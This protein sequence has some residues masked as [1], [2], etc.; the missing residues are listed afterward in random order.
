MASELLK[1]VVEFSALDDSN[2]IMGLKQINF[3]NGEVYIHENIYDHIAF[4]AYYPSEDILVCEG[5]HSTD[6]SFTLANGKETSETGNPEFFITSPN[7]RFRMNGSYDGQ[8][9]AGY[10]LQE[11]TNGSFEKIIDLEQE[12][13]KQTGFMI[14]N[15]RDGFWT[16][17]R[18]LYVEKYDFDLKSRYKYLKIKIL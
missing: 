1:G 11:F 17:D 14:C 7:S 15:A 10:F 13:E 2:E 3:R 6:I 5:G 8:E 12:T 16:D 18:T 9:C 4:T